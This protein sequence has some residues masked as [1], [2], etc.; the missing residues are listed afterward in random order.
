M[1]KVLESEQQESASS[2]LY[3]PGVLHSV[4]QTKLPKRGGSFVFSNQEWG[5][6]PLNQ[7][8]AV[9]P[10]RRPLPATTRLVK[11]ALDPR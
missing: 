5:L 7:I 6:T 8:L 2:D 9:T 1:F 10:A 11:L 3:A 4:L